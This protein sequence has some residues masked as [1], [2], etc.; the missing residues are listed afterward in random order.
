[1]ILKQ[2]LYLN[3]PC[4]LSLDYDAKIIA[5]E[6][7]S[8]MA[9]G[10]FAV[11][12]AYSGNLAY[13]VTYYAYRNEDVQTNWNFENGFPFYSVYPFTVAYTG[14]IGTEAITILKFAQ[15]P[16]SDEKLSEY[17]LDYKELMDRVDNLLVDNQELQYKLQIAIG[18]AQVATQT[19]KQV[20]DIKVSNFIAEVSKLKV[21]YG[22]IIKQCDL[23]F[24]PEEKEEVFKTWPIQSLA[25]Y[26]VMY[27]LVNQLYE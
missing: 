16:T 23:K 20:V 14:I 24:T 17:E 7:E 25:L 13:P 9:A 22:S 18:D 27:N 19:L 21:E 3:N 12:I 2:H 26:E 4:N 8:W 1:M 11:T 5:V 10:S 6:Q 15:G